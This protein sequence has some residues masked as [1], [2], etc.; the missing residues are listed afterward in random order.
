MSTS[1]VREIWRHRERGDAYLVE[2]E[3]DRVVSADGPLAEDQL[4][5]RA[6]AWKQ[7]AA[8]RGP[9]FTPEAAELDGRRHEFDRER[10]EAPDL[11]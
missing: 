10:V 6:L 7:A 9:A 3:G 8:G 4:G 11:S 5:E 1:R 2:L